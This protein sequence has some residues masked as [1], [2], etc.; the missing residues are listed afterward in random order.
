MFGVQILIF[1]L[2]SIAPTSEMAVSTV[3]SL[4]LSF[5]NLFFIWMVAS[6]RVFSSRPAKSVNFSLF[7]LCRSEVRQRCWKLNIWLPWVAMSHDFSCWESII[8]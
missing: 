7:R 3:C 8:C 1:S 4:V 2:M 6:L 5:L